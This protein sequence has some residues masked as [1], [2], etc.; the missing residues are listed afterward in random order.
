MNRWTFPSG[1]PLIADFHLWSTNNGKYPPW[2]RVEYKEPK[3]VLTQ[4]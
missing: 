1:G 3:T 2:M 4:S